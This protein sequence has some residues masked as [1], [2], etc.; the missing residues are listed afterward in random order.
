[1]VYY[2][3]FVKQVGKKVIIKIDMYSNSIAFL[4]TI[5]RNTVRTGKTSATVRNYK[6]IRVL[7]D[8]LYQNG[9][10]FGYVI[11]DKFI[12]LKFKYLNGKSI[13]KECVYQSHIRTLPYHNVSYI[14]QLNKKRIFVILST[15]EG[16]CTGVEAVD[17]KTGGKI[18]CLIK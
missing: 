7:V 17:R 13:I 15:K 8:L 16:V 9:Y 6:M 12:V 3:E 1:M 11:K 18:I 4:L 14:K 5:I 2:Q 10:L